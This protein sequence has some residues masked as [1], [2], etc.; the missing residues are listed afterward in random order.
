MPRY[1]TSKAIVI[2]HR[3]FLE[4]DQFISLLT[5]NDGKIVAIAKGVR[6]PKSH[7]RGSLELGNIIKAVVYEKNDHYW[8]TDTAVISH[9]LSATKSLTQLNLIFYFLEITNHFVAENQQLDGVF[10]TVSG[11]LHAV[12]N[13][14]FNSLIRHE[15][16]LLDALGFGIPDEISTTYN[17]QNLSDCQKHIKTF[18]ESIIERPLKS[19]RLFK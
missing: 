6:S 12:N 14:D 8:L 10:D 15:I 3:D 18:L 11:L 16:S 4:S 19:S 9:T 7:R 2:N 17:Q 1:L 5:E 13:N